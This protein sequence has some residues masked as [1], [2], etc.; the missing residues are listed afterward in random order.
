MNKN[1]ELELCPFC[2]G[3]AILEHDGDGLFVYC[4]DCECQTESF[5]DRNK[6]VGIWNHRATPKVDEVLE[7]LEH[8]ICGDECA[9]SV[10]AKLKQIINRG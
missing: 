10:I 1:R 3:E 8:E 5:M 7:K 6:V 9:E 4:V 2:D